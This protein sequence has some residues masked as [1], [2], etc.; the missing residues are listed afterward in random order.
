M[1]RRVQGSEEDSFPS[2]P[3]PSLVYPGDV[4]GEQDR[5][6]EKEEKDDER[7]ADAGESWKHE[8]PR[9]DLEDLWSDVTAPRD[10]FD[11]SSQSLSY[12][13]RHGHPAC[14]T[15]IPET[16]EPDYHTS[17]NIDMRNSTLSV[18]CRTSRSVGCDTVDLGPGPNFQYKTEVIHT[19]NLQTSS[20]PGPY[21]TQSCHSC[22][23]LT[24]GL[25]SSRSQVIMLSPRDSKDVRRTVSIADLENIGEEYSR[26][27]SR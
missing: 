14:P 4:E 5:R 12:P 9:L 3:D 2:L 18:E 10:R 8:V 27:V 25:H 22:L 11:L 13:V 23:N 15:P 21:P 7:L 26:T 6:E 16:G 19:P 17:F 20:Q 1:F 24:Q